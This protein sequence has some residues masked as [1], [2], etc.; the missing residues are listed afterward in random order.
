MPDPNREKIEWKKK[1][2]SRTYGTITKDRTFVSFGVLE[3]E[4]KEGRAG[5]N[6]RRN[7]DWKLPKL[8]KGINLQIH[9]ADQ[10]PN[11]INQ[12]NST[13]IPVIAKLTKTRLRKYL[14][15]GKWEKGTFS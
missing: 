4:E 5:T 15:S 2:S 11:R 6:S 3:G 9:E 14:E 7:N 10:T 12:K 13:S 8:G 1:S